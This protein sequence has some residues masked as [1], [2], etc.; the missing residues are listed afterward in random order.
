MGITTY[1]ELKTAIA[2]WLLRDDLTAVIPSFIAL[3]EADMNRQLVHWRMESQAALSVSSQFTAL[4]SDF[5]QPV[6]LS[7]AS[8][9]PVRA[10]MISRADMQDRRYRNADTGG[11]P[12]FYAIS[13]GQIEVYPT[14]DATYSATLT[15]SAI[16]E[17]LSDSNATNWV[18]TYHPDIYLMGAL[19]MAA[20]YLNN[21]E[22]LGTF[23]TLYRQAVTAA[24]EQS[25]RA[26]WGASGLRIKIGGRK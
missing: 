4:P 19:S 3:A 26:Q 7:I 22:R 14:P 18:L 16:P 20:P 10:E 5:L 6:S 1:T 11:T 12:C 9:S 21:D 13:N 25:G 24:N 17:A 23:A 15:Y 8:T 2:D